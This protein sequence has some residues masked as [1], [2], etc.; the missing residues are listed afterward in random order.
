MGNRQ[1]EKRKWV[2]FFLVR[3]PSL[4]LRDVALKKQVIDKCHNF[5]G[6]EFVVNPL[7]HC[8]V[9]LAQMNTM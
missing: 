5:H 9:L 1:G 7:G 8:P 4:K 2:G 3:L 6:E